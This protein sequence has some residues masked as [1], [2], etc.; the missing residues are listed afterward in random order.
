VRRWTARA[1]QVDVLAQSSIDVKPEDIS[2]RSGRLRLVSVDGGH[3]EKATLNDLRLVEACLSPEGVVVV[4]DYFNQHWPD[5]STGTA[6][7]LLDPRSRL[8]PFAITPNKLYLTAE[9][10]ADLYRAR[11]AATG[12]FHVEKTSRMFGSEVAI[13]GCRPPTL[14]LG[15]SARDLIKASAIGPYALGVK[16]ILK[17]TGA[18]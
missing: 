17:G 18:T 6:K 4:D 8:R 15:R 1:G 13:Y 12:Q 2:V 14:S 11:L 9:R 7:Y 10:N 5:V 16:A 3:T